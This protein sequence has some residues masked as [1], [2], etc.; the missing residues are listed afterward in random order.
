MILGIPGRKQQHYGIFMS[1]QPDGLPWQVFREFALAVRTVL[2]ND[3]I[4]AVFSKICILT[5]YPA[6]YHGVNLFD[7]PVPRLA[8]ERGSLHSDTTST[9]TI[10]TRSNRQTSFFSKPATMAV[11]ADP[12]R[13]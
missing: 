9:G 1:S 4:R 7:S 3:V 13:G 8:E 2:V 5:P 11:R 12:A 10:W 6:V